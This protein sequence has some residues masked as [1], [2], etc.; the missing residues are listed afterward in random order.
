VTSLVTVASIFTA[1]QP[2]PAVA[3]AAAPKLHC[4]PFREHQSAICPSA[5]QC[6]TQLHVLGLLG[7]GCD[8]TCSHTK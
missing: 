3:H 1:A 8:L 5:A 7:L 6:R 2:L 4:S